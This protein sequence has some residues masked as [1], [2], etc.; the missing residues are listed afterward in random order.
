MSQ[1]MNALCLYGVLNA[2]N[3]FSMCYMMYQKPYIKADLSLIA[4]SFR[5]S[6]PLLV[7]VVKKP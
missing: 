2:E 5:A 3:L 1:P 4:A 7:G 6:A